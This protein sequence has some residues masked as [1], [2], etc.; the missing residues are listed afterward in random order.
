M[1]AVPRGRSLGRSGAVALVAWVLEMSCVRAELVPEVG[2]VDARVR[3]APYEATEVYRV[4]GRVGYALDIEFEAGERFQGL[5][6]GDL[7]GVDFSAQGTHLFIKPKAAPVATNLTVLTDRRV[8][9]FDYAVASATDTEANARVVFALRFE[10]PRAAVV[11]VKSDTPKSEE[12]DPGSGKLEDV[13]RRSRYGFCGA[14]EVMP[15]AVSDDGV[16]TTLVFG[17]HQ[18]LPAVFGR[19]SDGSEGLVNFT[20]EGTSVIVHRVSERWVLRR[21]RAVGCLWGTASSRPADG[22]PASGGSQ[23]KS[24]SRSRERPSAEHAPTQWVPSA[25]HAAPQVPQPVRP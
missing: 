20:V 10:Y 1:S 7:E 15:T 22:R 13:P 18:P 8:Y 2:K 5:A 9:R 16:R 24:G 23:E 6:T 21:G 11:A 12:V 25:G 14:R 3:V 17:A 4:Q 19:E